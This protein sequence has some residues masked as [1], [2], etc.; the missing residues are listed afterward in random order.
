M[1]HRF[2]KI[3][4]TTQYNEGI[5]NI[6]G[7]SEGRTAPLLSVI[8]KECERP[9]FI[10]TSTQ[11]RAKGLYEDISFFAGEKEIYLIPEDE[12]IF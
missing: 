1:E 11:Q 7:L 2:R 6:S 4:N 12:K 8:S 3:K 5:I 9:M 10:I